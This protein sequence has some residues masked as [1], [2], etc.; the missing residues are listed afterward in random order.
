[1]ESFILVFAKKSSFIQTLVKFDKLCLS[2][3]R[4]INFT[5]LW[6][7]FL[8]KFKRTVKTESTVPRRPLALY[9][10]RRRRRTL[11]C[12]GRRCAG[13]EC[14]GCSRYPRHSSPLP[15]PISKV[16]QEISTHKWGNVNFFAQNHII[17]SI[18]FR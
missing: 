7:H 14:R 3:N 12:S 1:M 13:A 16:S 6:P 8:R 2:N 17:F 4:V 18:F 10:R 11:P 9:R 15:P 5:I